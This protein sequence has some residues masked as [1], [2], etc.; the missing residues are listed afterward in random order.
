MHEITKR[1]ALRK[2]VA[3][4][5]RQVAKEGV[6]LDDALRAHVTAVVAK[7]PEAAVAIVACRCHRCGRRFIYDAITTDPD[8][9]A[10]CCN[11]EPEA[12]GS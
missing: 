6:S 3:A 5:E 4:A 9:C 11:L 2:I 12:A 8:M 10:Y 1:I 7:W